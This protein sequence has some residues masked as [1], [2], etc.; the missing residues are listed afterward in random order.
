MWCHFISCPLDWVSQWCTQLRCSKVC[1]CLVPCMLTCTLRDKGSNQ[2]LSFVLIWYRLDGF[3]P[4]I[5]TWDEMWVCHFELESK[6]QLVERC[7]T[8]SQTKKKFKNALSAGKIV[9]AVCWD[10]KCVTVLNFLLRGAAVN[11]YW[12][13]EMLRFLK[14]HCHQ[15]HRTN[16]RSVAIQWW[17]QAIP[18]CAHHWGNHRI[19]IGSV[20]ILIVQSWPHTIIF[21]P[22]WSFQPLSTKQDAYVPLN[23]N[24]YR[25]EGKHCPMEV[26]KWA[27][28]GGMPCMNTIT[29][30]M[31]HCRM[32]SLLADEEDQLSLSGNTCSCSKG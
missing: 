18:K 25:Q 28:G 2:H 13:I 4:Q 5:F 22:L 12:S 23:V 27:F 6:W 24:F 11:C 9:A 20:T 30:M 14:A 8:T 7:H 32:P 16:V 3:L 15:V 21:P 17:C 10:E 1:T 19:W 31:R 26:Q 29:G